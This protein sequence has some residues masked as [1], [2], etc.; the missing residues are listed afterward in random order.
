M[1]RLSDALPALYRARSGTDPIGVEAARVLASLPDQWI[2]TPRPAEPPHQAARF[3]TAAL[4][5]EGAGIGDQLR[6]ILREIAPLLGWRYSYPP[7]ADAAATIPDIA[8]AELVG[9]RGLFDSAEVRVG[10]TLIGPD[11]SY[12]AHAHPAVELYFVLSGTAAWTADGV[13]TQRAPGDWVLHERSV[14][15]AMRT[16]AEPLLA[17]YSWTGDILSPSVYVE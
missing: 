12:P 10:L 6:P 8:F 17:V 4:A 14:A 16:E 5:G 11:T 7:R 13:E 1:Q 15:H 9:P 3:L 2:V